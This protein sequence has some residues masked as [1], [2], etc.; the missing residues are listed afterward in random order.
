MEYGVAMF[1]T[2]SAISPGDLA[3]ALEER[4]FESV[5]FPDH[6]PIPVS[7]KTYWPGGDKLPPEYYSAWD[8]ANCGSGG[9]EAP[10]DRYRGLPCRRTWSDYHSQGSRDPEHTSRCRP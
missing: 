7:R 4:G 5:F 9:D 6:S 2:E 3:R 1:P 10:N 8:P